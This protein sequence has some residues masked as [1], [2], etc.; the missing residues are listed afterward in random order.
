MGDVGGLQKLKVRK[1]LHL[2]R[3]LPLRMT[4]QK[5]LLLWRRKAGEDQRLPLVNPKKVAAS[6]KA[7]GKRGRPKKPATSEDEASE[8]DAENGDEAEEEAGETEE[9][10]E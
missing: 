5:K 1:S 10:N 9:G 2:L 3:G 6:K 8:E 7:G 4:M